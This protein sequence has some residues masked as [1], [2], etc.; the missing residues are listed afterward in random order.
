MKQAIGFP[1]NDILRRYDTNLEVLD[2]PQKCLVSTAIGRA[3]GMHEYPAGINCVIII[4]SI[5][6]WNSEDGV[7]FRQS[8]IDYGGMASTTYKTITVEEYFQKTGTI[9]K[10]G[11]PDTSIRK[12][13]HNY[14]LLDERGI[15]KRGSTVTKGDIIVGRVREITGKNK[16]TTRQDCSE[17]CDEDGIVERAEMFRTTMGYY[18]AKIIIKVRKIPERGDK[19]A[20]LCAQK[21]TVGIIMKTEDM[22]FSQVTGIIPDIIINPNA[23][24]SRMTISML[25]E[26]V[27][28][29]ECALEG[30]L[31]D[32]TPF[33]ENS[34]DISTRIGKVLHKN[35]FERH[36]WESMIC[37]TTGKPFLAQIFTGISFYQKL[38]HMVRDKMHARARGD[39]TTLT[40]QPLAGRS[41][42][43]G[44]RIGEMERDTLI[45]QGAAQFLNERM[46]YTSDKFMVILCNKCHVISKHKDECHICGNTDVIRT[47]MPYATKYLFQLLYSC[48][49]ATKFTATLV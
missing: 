46:F 31:G 1:T 4:A 42:D 9:K 10:F 12:A 13:M 43:G 8:F 37:G 40:R 49:I 3:F 20:N 16:T 19:F 29:K 18:M 48:M 44:L 45:G 47:D 7:V 38:K 30:T 41:K 27:V 25:L 23:L 32:A 6:S 5:E 22:P 2:Y 11:L 14:N 39:V 35:G 36:G 21:G 34:V 33:T 26:M 24:P 28:G 15:V 17:I